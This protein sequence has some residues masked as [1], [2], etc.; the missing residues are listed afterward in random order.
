MLR[1][2]L[3]L[4]MVIAKSGLRT[5]LI[6]NVSSSVLTLVNMYSSPG[7]QN[8]VSYNSGQGAFTSFREQD[9]EA[10]ALDAIF[11]MRTGH[12]TF[13]TLFGAG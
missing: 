8:S 13:K 11:P 5:L 12:S 6:T 3:L 4:I 7:K 2:T 1:R 10:A 9:V